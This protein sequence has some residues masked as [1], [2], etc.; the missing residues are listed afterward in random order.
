MTRLRRRFYEL[1][2]NG[3]SQVATQ[4]VTTMAKLWSVEEEVR[5]LFLPHAAP[6]VRTVPPPSSPIPSG[7][8]KR[9]CGGSRENQ[10]EVIRYAAS[11]RAALE[12]F[13]ADGRV[14]IDSDI[15]ERAI[16]PQT[17][18]RK[19]ALLPAATAVE[20]RGRLSRPFCRPPR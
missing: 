3:S 16:R 19:N 1:H 14:E 5:G 7:A 9:S 12:R 17:I 10:T 2:T 15:V 18:V 8:G 11:R 6:P 13:L 20:A 4:S